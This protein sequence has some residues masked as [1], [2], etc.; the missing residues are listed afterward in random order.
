MLCR[1]K[2]RRGK[3]RRGILGGKRA[4]FDHFTRASAGARRL[5]TLTLDDEVL[6]SLAARAAGQTT[7]TSTTL[8]A[9][10]ETL[11]PACLP[12]R[13]CAALRL[14][15]PLCTPESRKPRAIAGR[16][17]E[18]LRNASDIRP[19]RRA[20]ARAL[21]LVARRPSQ[22]E[23]AA[24]P[25][26]LSRRHQLVASHSGPDSTTTAPS[27]SGL[28][29]PDCTRHGLELAADGCH[30]HR[31]LA[32]AHQQRSEEDL[33]RG[34]HR[35]DREQGRAAGPRRRTYVLPLHLTAQ[36]RRLVANR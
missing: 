34:G 21:T 19:S 24:A 15:H 12:G 1:G 10:S 5:V 26:A 27:G 2:V 4:S 17:E 23:S 32:D 9:C 28:S 3:V 20:R 35:A 14:C 33:Q 22:V 36:F 29:A 13:R 30:H 6:K 11:A 8:P 16:Q 7:A 18:E 31:A 25:H